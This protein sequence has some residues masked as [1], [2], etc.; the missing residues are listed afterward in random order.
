MI[1]I[2]IDI[3]KAKEFEKLIDTS[4]G[5]Y[6]SVSSKLQEWINA[7]P[8]NPNIQVTRDIKVKL[9]KI[10]METPKGLESIIN[11]FKLNGHQA[12]IFNTATNKLTPFGSDLKT[13]FNY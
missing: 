11:D 9:K 5:K 1:D 10:I 2:K 8:M 13:I 4:K 7:N 12:R 3:K 6:L